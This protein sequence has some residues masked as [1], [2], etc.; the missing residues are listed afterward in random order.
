M[1]RGMRHL[2]LA[3]LLIKKKVEAKEIKLLKVTSA[4]ND[5]NLELSD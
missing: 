4:D 1:T 2:N 3:K 5:S